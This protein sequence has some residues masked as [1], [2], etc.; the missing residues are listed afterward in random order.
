MTKILAAFV[1]SVLGALCLPSLAFGGLI[2]K[3]AIIVNES[4][5]TLYDIDLAMQKN[6]LSK[7]KAA[8]LLID[9]AIRAQKIKE[10]GVEA[11]ALDVEEKIDEIA[12]QNGTSKDELLR[13]IAGRG[14]DLSE[15]REKIKEGL[16][17][18]RLYIKIL[19][20]ENITISE[21]E[22]SRYYEAHRGEFKTSKAVEV[23]QYVSF[24]EEDLQE[25]IKNPLRNIQGIQKQEQ[26]LELSNINE[27]LASLLNSAKEKSFTPVFALQDRF[28]TLYI[29]RKI[30]TEESIKIHKEEIKNILAAQMRKKVLEDY[31]LTQKASANIIYTD[32]V[33]KK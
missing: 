29:K 13:F 24:S 8:Q 14:M 7:E 5:I 12:A 19:S 27:N 2:N 10:L 32:L 20:N 11:S 16:I 26:I 28:F 23:V 30:G 1:A 6:G 3:V 18:E 17:N 21:A 22:I 4:P 33:S 15:Y 9:E 31:F 25:Y